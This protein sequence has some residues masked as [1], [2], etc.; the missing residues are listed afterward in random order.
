MVFF[1][2]SFREMSV[3]ATMK[4]FNGDNAMN[5]KTNM[6]NSVFRLWSGDAPGNL[7]KDDKDIPTL[8]IY[9]PER[10]TGAAV[11]VCPGGGY[12]ILAPHEAGDYAR[13]LNEQGVMG[14]VLKYRLASDG[15]RYPAMFQDV[16]RAMRY[17]RYKADEWGIDADR[18]GIMGSS[19]GGHLAAWMLTHFDYGKPDADDPIERQN[20]RPDLGILCYPVISFLREIGHIGCRNNVLGDDPSPDMI[21]LL[22]N[23]LQVTP[24]TAPCFL[25]HTYEDAGVK[26]E[27]SLAFSASLSKSKV[28]FELHIYQKG[29]HGLGLGSREYDPKKWHPW[30]AECSRWLKEQGFEV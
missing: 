16:T 28:P 3:L 17:V 29:A 2:F 4:L 8:T 15:Y 27:N 6:G 18:I 24:E 11:V 20:S 1:L 9:M 12:N 30:T 13:W 23:E 10:V 14:L 19:A 22:S 5:D 25:W 21:Q 26:V 7:G